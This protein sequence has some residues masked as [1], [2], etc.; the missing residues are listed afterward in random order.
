VGGGGIKSPGDRETRRNRWKPR[1]QRKRGLKEEGGID[2][3][4]W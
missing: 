4:R 2:C 3:V 1:S